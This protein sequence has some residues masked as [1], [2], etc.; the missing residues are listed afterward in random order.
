M[1]PFGLKQLDA[2]WMQYMSTPWRWPPHKPKRVGG[3]IIVHVSW[4][5][6]WNLYVYHALYI[7][8]QKSSVVVHWIIDI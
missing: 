2:S 3:K 4:K 5:I 8:Q 7:K 1:H 6:L